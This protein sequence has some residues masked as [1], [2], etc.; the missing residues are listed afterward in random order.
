MIIYIVTQ[1]SYDDYSI[2]GV[3][4]SFEKAN[5]VLSQIPWEGNI[6]EWGLNKV[7]AF[8]AEVFKYKDMPEKG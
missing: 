7:G 8:T 5:F 1:G 2:I 4:D 3:Y 6:E